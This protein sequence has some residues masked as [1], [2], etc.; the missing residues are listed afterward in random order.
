MQ[1]HRTKLGPKFSEGAR[2]LWAVMHERGWGLR[3]LARQI[4]G[5]YAAP[6]WL[7]GDKLPPFERAVDI[8]RLFSIAPRLWFAK[9]R[10]LFVVP[11]LRKA[12]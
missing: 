6:H 10:R 4:G 9:P 3:E 5:P 7:Y 1:N 2:Q 11:A 12:A 8:E